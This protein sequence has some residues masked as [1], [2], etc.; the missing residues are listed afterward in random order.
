MAAVDPDHQLTVLHQVLR[1]PRQSLELSTNNSDYDSCL[2]LLLNCRHVNYSSIINVQDDQGNTAL[3][4]AT[5]F[6][7]SATINKL[8]LLGANIGLKNNLGETPISN[9]LPGTMEQFL[10]NHCIKSEGNPTN[11]DFKIS[12]H[13]DFLAPPR[14]ESGE[15]K[16]ILDSETGENSVRS[17][18]PET[19][20]L[21]YMARSKEHCHLLKHPV[22][23]SFL[24][25]KW[26]RLSVHYNANMI[27][28]F[29]LV[30]LMT[31]YIF[32]NYAGSSV[33][34]TPPM[35]TNNS[36]GAGGDQGSDQGSWGN[37]AGLWWTVTVL[38]SVLVLR[39][40][41]QFSV[42]PSQ[43]LAS[44]ENI[45]EILLLVLSFILLFQGQPGCDLVFKREIAT[46]V[47]LISWV[48]MVTMI[49]NTEHC[50]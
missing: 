4:Y 31:A 49:G 37:S 34:V 20:V 11:E 17:S 23:T 7:D 24:A 15:V 47:L 2:E 3:H 12:F 43:Y 41:V 38:L 30:S 42:H 50:L 45:L 46:S 35:C 8:L 33:G 36:T 13:Y 5:Q 40:L 1:R 28:S 25:L 6:W 26:S 48:L 27:F 18:Q 14:D 22:I 21:W 39:E 29:L 32:T 16:E 19:D 44:T 10:N 9:I